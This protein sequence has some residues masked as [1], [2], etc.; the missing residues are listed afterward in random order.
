MLSITE[1]LLHHFWESKDFPSKA[2]QT[3]E[4]ESLQIIANG[5]HNPD[6]GPD[7]LQACIEIGDKRWSGHV[8]LHLR[9]SDWLKHRHS[10]DANYRNVI[11]HVVYE[12]DK[13]IVYPNGRHIPTLALKHYLPRA[14]IMRYRDW[15]HTERH[16]PCEHHLHEIEPA[17]LDD[18]LD[19][20]F[21]QRVAERVQQ[22]KSRLDALIGDWEALFFEHL[23]ACF[24][25]RINRGAFQALGRSF[26]FNVLR[27]CQRDPLQLAALL[28]GQAGFLK[29]DFKDDYPNALQQTYRFLRSKY[30][31]T[32]LPAS[33]FKRYRLRPA[34]FP[35]LRLAQLSALYTSQKHLLSALLEAPSQSGIQALFQVTPPPYWHT[36]YSFD[37]ST[38]YRQKKASRAFTQLLYAN[39][40]L[41]I[42]YLYHH[43]HG[44]SAEAE[45]HLAQLSQL[46][47][48]HNAVIRQF[49]KLGVKPKNMLQ[50]QALLQLKK[51]YCDAKKCLSCNI[52]IQMLK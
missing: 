12:H 42:T 21:K 38:A 17:Y 8:E 40:I 27:K 20:V 25:L 28:H 49:E 34:S 44:N 48:E 1:K 39:A 46:P 13:T 10:P 22:A 35:S 33:R 3:T 14:K 29:G 41:P 7:F 11:L 52:G 36:H 15:M 37:Q 45:K 4:G 51:H 18:W 50:T 16:V 32:P 5:E 31:L 26:P 30:R 43:L 19:A 23:C 24:G 47:A 6:A 2:L 9:S